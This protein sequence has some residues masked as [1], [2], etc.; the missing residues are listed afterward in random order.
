MPWLRIGE[1]REML[2]SV[3]KQR[4]V[5]TI[6]LPAAR[7]GNCPRRPRGR[8]GP[9]VLPRCRPDL[10][11]AAAQ[12][13]SSIVAL[14]VSRI[15]SVAPAE[16]EPFFEVGTTTPTVNELASA[17]LAYC[18]DD[19]EEILSADRAMRFHLRLPRL[20]CSPAGWDA[21]LLPSAENGFDPRRICAT[22]YLAWTRGCRLR[23]GSPR[24]RDQ[25]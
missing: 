14:L 18:A 5:F 19:C 15:P 23:R 20:G 21:S 3:Q 22:L 13:R 17:L 7:G 10:S 2:S 12:A 1:P 6:R 16:P 24:T 11:S 4:D 25:K 8:G 9:A